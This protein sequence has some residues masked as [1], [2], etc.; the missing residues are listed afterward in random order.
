MKVHAIE[1]L[2][3]K[4]IPL[5]YRNEYAALGDIEFP[6]GNR[7]QVPVEFSVEIKPTGDRCIAVSVPS[8]I[9]YPL[10]PVIRA[11]KDKIRTM[12]QEGELR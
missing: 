8:R 3:K 10:I 6:G 2:T 4:D 1:Q 5:Y 7:Q 12:E 11:L 9:D